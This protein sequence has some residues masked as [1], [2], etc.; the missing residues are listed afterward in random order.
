MVGAEEWTV[1]QSV[2]LDARVQRHPN[3][4]V[5]SIVVPS[6]SERNQLDYFL[7]MWP[8]SAFHIWVS[9]T[10]AELR[11]REPT[12]DDKAKKHYAPITLRE[13]MLFL[14]GLL[15]MTHYGLPRTEF[16]AK[17]TDLFPTIDLK[18]LI[19][20][21]RNRFS[22]I[23]FC[24]RFAPPLLGPESSEYYQIDALV[25]QFHQSRSGAAIQIGDELC[26]DE[27]FSP[28]LG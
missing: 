28:W 22:A 20:I 14:A 10:N 24:L 19:G 1:L 8:S 18:K 17:S 26:I 5:T 3:K 4:C 16:W 23:L 25:A 12:A 7:A 2:A 6:G 21:G 13:L 27:L 9:A 15:F 11:K